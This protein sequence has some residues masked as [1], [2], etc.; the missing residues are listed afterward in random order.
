MCNSGV[1]RLYRQARP[2]R[3]YEGTS[4]LLQL[5]IARALCEALD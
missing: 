4:E 5:G 3:F 1:E 2:M